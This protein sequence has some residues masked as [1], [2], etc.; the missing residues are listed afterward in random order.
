MNTEASYGSSILVWYV[1]T[2]RGRSTVSGS[3]ARMVSKIERPTLSLLIR[4][5]C[6]LQLITIPCRPSKEKTH[7][8]VGQ[9]LQ[10][11]EAAAV[12]LDVAVMK[13]NRQDILSQCQDLGF[14]FS[15]TV[16]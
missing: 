8:S 13:N 1:R 14:D 3:V 16:Y 12:V 10:D 4:I 5:L 6:R 9:K 2:I 15:A 7:K 11:V